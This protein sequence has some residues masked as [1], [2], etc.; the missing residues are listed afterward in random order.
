[1]RLAARALVAMKLL[2]P[3]EI[4]R[5]NDADEQIRV[6]RNV[7]F[8]RLHRAMEAF[9]EQN[10]GAG[11]KALPRRERACL[12]PIGTRFFLVV[13]IS[14]HPPAS[15]LTVLAKECLQFLEEIGLSTFPPPPF[16]AY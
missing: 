5:R 1:M 8:L 10:V 13:Q 3:L 14:A 2:N 11:G 16:E 6:A 7:H 4:D 15:A 9:V 12:Q